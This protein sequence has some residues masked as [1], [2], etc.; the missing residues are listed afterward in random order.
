MHTC[1]SLPTDAGEVGFALKGAVHSNNSLVTLED[2]GGGDDSLHCMTDNTFCCRPPYEQFA[3]G[4]WFFPNETRVPSDDSRWDFHRTRGQSV[5]HL[6]RK[7]GGENGVYRCMV[8]DAMS[9]TQT[10]YI[11]V[12]TANTGERYTCTCVYTQVQT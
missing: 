2:I 9:V 11:G 4:N 1:L 10:I 8:P 6:Q 3:L 5:V 12:Y 7:R